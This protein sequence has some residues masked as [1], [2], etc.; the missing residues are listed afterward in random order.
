MTK[1]R[2][3]SL[4]SAKAGLD[5]KLTEAF[6]DAQSALVRETLK[7]GGKVMIPTL[8]TIYPQEYVIRNGVKRTA[9]PDDELPRGYN[10]RFTPDANLKFPRRRQAAARA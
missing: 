9:V 6:I 2:F 4:L 8:G 1:D 7:N 5:E 3:I 10:V